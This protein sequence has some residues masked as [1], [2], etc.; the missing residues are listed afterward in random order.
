[1]NK[2]VK[3]ARSDKREGDARS[4]NTQQHRG[5]SARMPEEEHTGRESEKRIRA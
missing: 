4:T 5:R 3:E 1:M 2:E